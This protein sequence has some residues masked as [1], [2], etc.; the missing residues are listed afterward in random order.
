MKT[1]KIMKKM[2]GQFENLKMG[3]GGKCAKNFHKKCIP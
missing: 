1:M 3:D 2:K